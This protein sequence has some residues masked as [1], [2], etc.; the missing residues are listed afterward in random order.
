M[1]VCGERFYTTIF[2]PTSRIVATASLGLGHELRASLASL[3]GS[4]SR[5][6]SARHTSGSLPTIFLHQQEPFASYCSPKRDGRR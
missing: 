1:S 5:A 4:D 3:I 2:F 6:A